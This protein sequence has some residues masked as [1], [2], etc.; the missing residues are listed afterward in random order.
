MSRR[1]DDIPRGSN[2]AKMR[3]AFFSP[4][5]SGL[6]CTSVQHNELNDQPGRVASCV[7]IMQRSH[8][9]LNQR[10]D[11]SIW[12][13][14][15]VA[16]QFRRVN[17]FWLQCSR[18]LSDDQFFYLIERERGEGKMNRRG[19]SRGGLCPMEN[20]LHMNVSLLLVWMQFLTTLVLFSPGRQS[21]TRTIDWG[22]LSR[23]CCESGACECQPFKACGLRGIYLIAFI[24]S[25]HAEI[26]NPF[27]LLKKIV[28]TE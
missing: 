26:R 18:V 12:S 5:V 9:L 21:S 14:F 27:P 23:F 3:A 11:N 25:R 6:R 7:W 10:D 13:Q 8:C 28:M 24:Q 16:I 1:Q 22:N 20:T 2:S 19:E 15:T 17:E 4:D